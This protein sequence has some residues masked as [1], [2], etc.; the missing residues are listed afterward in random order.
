MFPYILIPHTHSAVLRRSVGVTTAM[1][2]TAPAT[3]PARTPRAGESLP[4]ESARTFRMASNERKR[5]PALAAVPWLL[6][7]M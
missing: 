5:T 6:I 3:I 7:S 4:F 2:S 1:L